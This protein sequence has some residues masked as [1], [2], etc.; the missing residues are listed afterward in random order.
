MKPEHAYH[1][2]RHLMDKHGLSAWKVCFNTRIRRTA[3]QCIRPSKTI[4]LSLPSVKA[5]R[6]RAVRDLVLHEIAH[7]LTTGG[8]DIVWKKV[9]AAL[10]AVPTPWGLMKAPGGKYVLVCRSCNTRMNRFRRPKRNVACRACCGGKY[11]ARF[12]L[13]VY[14]VDA[15]GRVLEGMKM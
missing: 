2:A 3:G 14:C 7:A 9:A 8:H 12:K 11:D 10:G 1:L 15:E 13:E 6:V 4:E 5:N